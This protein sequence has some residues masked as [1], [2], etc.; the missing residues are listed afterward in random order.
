M[1]ETAVADTTTADATTAD[2]GTGADSTDTG[3]A[4]T[5]SADIGPAN[6]GPAN[7]GSADAGSAGKAGG[8]SRSRDGRG[9][10]SGGSQVARVIACYR[11]VSGQDD[12]TVQVAAALSG[13]SATAEAVT[14]AVFNRQTPGKVAAGVDQLR[15]GE[16]ADALVAALAMD[17][18]QL[19]TV[20]Q[21][22]T[23]LSGQHPA[24]QR[25]GSAAQQALTVVRAAR[26]ITPDQRARLDTALD[27]YETGR[28]QTRN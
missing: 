8:R 24:R 11:Q 23:A 27:L 20:G 1:T 28:R 17:H 25:G 5:G 9:N 4:N 2:T 3:S 15:D 7:T 22:V 14:E 10:R 21:A 19:A 26:Q 12:D 13:C 16:E 6:T 18:K